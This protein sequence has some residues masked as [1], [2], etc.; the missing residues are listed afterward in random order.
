MKAPE[1]PETSMYQKI[2]L[3]WPPMQMILD[4]GLPEEEV[5]I[6]AESIAET[7]QKYKRI[8]RNDQ[9]IEQ[10]EDFLFD[11]L[12]EYDILLDDSVLAELTARIIAY[13]NQSLQPNNRLEYNL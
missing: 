13:H 3:G 8:T 2:I 6:I 9:I 12:E 7:L 1:H 10:L 4:D 11:T 5:P